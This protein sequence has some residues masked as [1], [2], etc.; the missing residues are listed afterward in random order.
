M[1]TTSGL[2]RRGVAPV[3]TLVSMI[4]KPDDVVTGFAADWA[5]AELSTAAEPMASAM[6][7]HVA[8][9]LARGKVR[10]GRSS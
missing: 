5:M 6:A 2:A 1:R 7:V 4:C 8:M 10:I 9:M 3:P